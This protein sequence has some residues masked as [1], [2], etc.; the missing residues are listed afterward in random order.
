MTNIDKFA[1]TEKQVEIMRHIL[2]AA[3][4]GGYL[5]ANELYELLSYRDSCSVNAVLGSLK[6]L[7][8]YGFIQRRKRGDGTRR[9]DLIP[10]KFAYIYFR[11]APIEG[12]II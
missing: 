3:D 4:A 5:C 7:E 12:V 10:T 9:S 1:Q 11:P 6:F 8:R 2:K